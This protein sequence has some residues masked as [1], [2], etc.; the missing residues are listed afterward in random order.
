MKQ[1]KY[2]KRYHTR[3]EFDQFTLHFEEGGETVIRKREEKKPA[4]SS[5]W[6]YV[7]FAGDF[8]FTIAA[9]IAG[10]AFAGMW[11]DE[12][13]STYP[14]LTLSLLLFGVLVSIVGFI[15]IVKDLIKRKQ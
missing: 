7:G 8:G 15:R 3:D 4:G 13:F 11:L 12:R 1:V 5:I 6:Y 10:G 9:P 14:K 2:Q